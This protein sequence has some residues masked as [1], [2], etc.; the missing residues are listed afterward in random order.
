M[1]F[2]LDLWYIKG[3]VRQFMEEN[4]VK[5]LINE[6]IECTVGTFNGE[7]K[8]WFKLSTDRDN[9]IHVLVV[10]SDHRC[11]YYHCTYKLLSEMFRAEGS[12]EFADEFI[13]SGHDR[14]FLLDRN[15]SGH[16]DW[17]CNFKKPDDDEIA[18]FMGYF[19]SGARYQKVDK[20]YN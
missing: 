5:I 12:N 4:S 1:V 8:Y 10:E 16:L 15:G 13:K 19:M 3:E 20:Q 11:S 9:E 14:M 7:K 6:S 2:F 18:E 17:L